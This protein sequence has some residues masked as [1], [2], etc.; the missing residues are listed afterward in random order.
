MG[1][2]DVKET[3]RQ[4]KAE[5]RRLKAEEVS[6]RK[7]KKEENEKREE[8]MLLEEYNEISHSDLTNKDNTDNIEFQQNR[9][10]GQVDHNQ[11][12]ED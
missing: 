12:R 6:E 11:E 3:A 4:D 1:R 2:K 8:E 9:K 5:K 10:A 7:R